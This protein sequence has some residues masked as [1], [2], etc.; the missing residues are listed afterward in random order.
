MGFLLNV[1]VCKPLWGLW[2][3]LG[4]MGW[5]HRVF[6]M[7]WYEVAGHQNTYLPPGL[8]FYKKQKPRTTQKGT[9]TLCTKV[10]G[11]RG[12][13]RGALDHV[14][15]R[16]CSATAFLLLVSGTGGESRG[17]LRRPHPK[18]GSEARPG[19]KSPLS[20]ICPAPKDRQHLGRD[21]SCWCIDA[22]RNEKPPG[23]TLNT[24]ADW[25][26]SL[27]NCS[28]WTLRVVREQQ[29][30][31]QLIFWLDCPTPTSTPPN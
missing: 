11:R 29:T 25:S 28:L 8:S 14:W 6:L 3:R 16:A 17:I 31:T 15:Y 27:G 12:S 18:T 26:P 22:A 21:Q 30:E 2:E 24:A 1:M 19:A 23:P 10:H 9:S 13:V 4:Q 20:H 5:P 7:V